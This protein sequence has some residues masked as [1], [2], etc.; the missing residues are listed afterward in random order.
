MKEYTST[1]T[2]TFSLNYNEAQSKEE[3]IEKIKS[4]FNEQYGIDLMDD[5]ITDIEEVKIQEV[6]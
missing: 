5:E 3:Y 4:Q 2:V 1:V 6:A